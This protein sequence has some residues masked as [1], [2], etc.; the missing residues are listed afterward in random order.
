[1]ILDAG[2][3]PFETCYVP[4]DLAGVLIVIGVGA[5]KMQFRPAVRILKLRNLNCG[6]LRK[7]IISISGRAPAT[8]DIGKLQSFRKLVKHLG[9][10]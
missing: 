4:S 2:G 10:A 3:I 6:G 1:M 7:T 9:Y 5:A 8:V